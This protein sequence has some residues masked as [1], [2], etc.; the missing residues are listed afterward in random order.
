MVRVR[1]V[2]TSAALAV[3]AAS[4]ALGT[5]RAP[6]SSPSSW[7]TFRTDRVSVR[8]PGSWFATV[9]P[10]TPVTGPGQLLAIAS[11]PFPK[12]PRPNGCEP[13]GTL[14]KMPSDGAL[15]FVWYYGSNLQY[16]GFPPRP[17][18]FRLTGLARYECFGPRPS[19]MLRFRE[20]NRFF[21]IHIAF[22]HR[23][24]AATRATALRI[25]DSFMA[26]AV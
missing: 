9:R 26:R 6:A 16:S 25:L 21:Q 1:A 5:S 3:V 8:Y 14:A 23:A 15:I 4:A 17:A 13:A 2:G 10:L 7:P 22:G 12:E 19:Y 24:G 18:Q 20:S 11:Y